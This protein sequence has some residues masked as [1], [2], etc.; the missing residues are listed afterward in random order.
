MA[1]RIRSKNIEVVKRRNCLG[2]WSELPKTDMASDSKHRIERV[3]TGRTPTKAARKSIVNVRDAKEVER[4][5]MME[6][7]DEIWEK[8]IVKKALPMA[9]KWS[10]KMENGKETALEE[11]FV[12][13][14]FCN[15]FVKELKNVAWW[16]GWRSCWRL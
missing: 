3:A 10:G 1:K 15:V 6:K 5:Q 13:M 16:M 11:D 2:F 7:E 9:A 12:V 8:N 14:V 4:K